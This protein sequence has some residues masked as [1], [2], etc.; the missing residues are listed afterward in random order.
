MR[1]HS[2]TH[3][4]FPSYT[5]KQYTVGWFWI[6]ILN[7]QVQVLLILL[8]ALPPSNL[9]KDFKPQFLPLL[10]AS[11]W[12]GSD[13]K[14]IVVKSIFFISC[15]VI[16]IFLTS[17]FLLK[18]VWWTLLSCLSYSPYILIAKNMTR[19]YRVTIFVEWMNDLVNKW[20][21]PGNYSIHN[22]IY[23]RPFYI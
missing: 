3:H 12:K 19:L 23:I 15:R 6:L 5:V 16:I 20:N 18:W 17:Q 7:F 14:I 21:L 13:D 10:K 1:F 11:S 2:Q 22:C 8:A 4:P 9:H